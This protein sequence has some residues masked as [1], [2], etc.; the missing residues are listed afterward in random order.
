MPAISLTLN[1]SKN[2]D[3]YVAIFAALITFLTYAAVY[4]FRKP[5]TVGAF[6]GGPKIFGVAY[7][8]ALVISQV[9]GYMMSKFYGIRFIAELKK[10]GRGKMILL[11]VSISWAA[12]LL[13]AVVPPPF[14]VIFL[15]IN[16]FPLGMIWGIIFS[17]VEGRKATDFIGAS[18]AVSFIFSS[19]F[20]KSVA[21]WLMISFEV[22]EWWLPFITGLVFILPVLFLIFLLE[23]IPPPSNDD[24]DS[25]VVRLPMVK[26]ERRNFS[27]HFRTGLIFLITIYVFLTVFRDIRDN[28]AADIWRET[29]YGNE[30]SVFTAT[31]IPITI[32]VLLLIGSMILIRNNRK[33]FIITH[34]IIVVGF[35]L[36]GVSSW[37]FTHHQIPA[38]TWMTLVGMGLYM[39]Y[40]PFNCILF[41]RMIATFKYAGNVGFLM[42]LAD[43][44]GYLASVGVILMKSVFSVKIK[45]TTLYSNGVIYLSVI[46]VTGTLL[47]LQY[48]INKYKTS[49]A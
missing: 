17:F 26:E 10:V 21:K 44:F 24:V 3:T 13:F 2:R 27:H 34:L 4:A 47:A 36:A 28:F 45:W 22:T 1:D 25:R 40:I 29:G 31:E 7:K 9:L 16:G 30:P 46:G 15:F 18:L 33:A 14:N 11:L 41:D 49:T 8:D 12:L 5:F 43:S 6:A 42:Y 35:L 20:V 23:K 37:L 19:G 32:V 39:G 48:F 38:F